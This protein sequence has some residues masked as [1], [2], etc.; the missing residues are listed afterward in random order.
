MAVVQGL[1]KKT[2]PRC[3]SQSGVFSVMQFFLL[4][5]RFSFLLLRGDINMCIVGDP[6]TSKSQLLTWV[7]SFAPRAVFASGKGSTAAGLTAAVVR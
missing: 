3:W 5:V 1:L 2:L 4:P 6:S 7:E